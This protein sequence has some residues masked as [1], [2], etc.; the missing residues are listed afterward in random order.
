MDNN[1]KINLF[2]QTFNINTNISETGT[3]FKE[4]FLGHLRLIA[5]I[6]L[7]HYNLDLYIRY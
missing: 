7:I 1:N 2:L 4:I 3:N 5:S 6:T